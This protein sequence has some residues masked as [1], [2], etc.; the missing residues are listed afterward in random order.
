MLGPQKAQKKQQPKY[1]SEGGGSKKKGAGS[2]KGGKKAAKAKSKG[3]E[4][5]G[6]TEMPPSYEE[7]RETSARSAQPHTLAHSH[8]PLSLSL[9]RC[10]AS[11]TRMGRSAT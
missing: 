8:H 2:S 9:C 4:D 6:P 10:Y 5:E 7:V 3:G 11:T 1:S